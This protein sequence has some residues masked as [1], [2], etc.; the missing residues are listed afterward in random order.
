M[1]G[2]FKSGTCQ[3]WSVCVCARG[4]EYESSSPLAFLICA[5]ALSHLGSPYSMKG[6][7]CLEQHHII[8]SWDRLVLVPVQHATH[9]LH[10]CE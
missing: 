3:K 4:E 2:T 10:L 9:G 6:W 8:S 1:T 7:S 5:P